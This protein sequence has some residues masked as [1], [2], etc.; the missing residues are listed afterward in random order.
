MAV[1]ATV[2]CDGMSGTER[3]ACF[4]S[5][6]SKKFAW[7]NTIGKYGKAHRPVGPEYGIS[8]GIGIWGLYRV[9]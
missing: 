2:P 7:V 6:L 4:T 1:A 3:L 9:R 8:T 5:S